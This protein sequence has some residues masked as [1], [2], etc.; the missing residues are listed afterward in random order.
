M[1]TLHLRAFMPII[2][3]MGKH[4]HKRRT[5][6]KCPRCGGDKDAGAY[7][8]FCKREYAKRWA[9]NNPQSYK[10][11]YVP[12]GNPVGRPKGGSNSVSIGRLISRATRLCDPKYFASEE[13]S[14]AAKR[15]RY[16][17]QRDDLIAY[18]MRKYR[19]DPD[20][21]KARAYEWKRANPL[22]SKLHAAKSAKKN[23]VKRNDYQNRRQAKAREQLSDHYIR[24]TLSR[25]PGWPALK[26][27]AIPGELVELERTLLRI[28]RATRGI[29][30]HTC[31]GCSKAFR[32]KSLRSNG[33]CSH[34]C[35]REC[36]FAN[37]HQWNVYTKNRKAN[38]D[39]SND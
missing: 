27:T 34:Y 36:A 12:T 2:F 30:T 17:K 15:S 3:G 19:A 24:R 28:K 39:Q 10:P 37:H 35:S 9:K 18:Q 13:R 38:D 32:P 11:V 4:L 23:R 5:D 29:T 20:A 6:G 26:T 8:L 21:Y 1:S 14:A 25:C 7:C 22:A 33:A 16:E 31:Q